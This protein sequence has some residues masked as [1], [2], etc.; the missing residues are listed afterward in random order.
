MKV[1]RTSQHSGVTR[2]L[3]IP[4]TPEQLEEWTTSRR[5][6]QTIMPNLSAADREFLMTGITQE[7]WDDIFKDDDTDEEDV[8]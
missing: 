7:E 8:A 4:C 3:E 1:T 5:P 2:T 6:I